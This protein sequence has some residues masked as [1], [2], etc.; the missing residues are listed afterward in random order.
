MDLTQVFELIRQHGDTAYAFIFA[1]AASHSMLIVLLAGYAANMGALD[2]GK[3]VLVCWAGSCFGDV[4]RFWIGRRF[5]TRW[6][7]RFPRLERAVQ[8][9]ARLVDH[10]YLW[11]PMIH[12]YPNGIRSVAG[13]A[14]GMSRLPRST[15]HLLNVV[16]AGIWAVAMVSIGYAFGHIS[17]KTLSDTA[18]GLSLAIMLVFMGLFWILSKRLE[19][20]LERG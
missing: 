4:V 6:L 14:F 10:H 2:W 1:Y 19:R 18:S 3:L 11:I 7:N 16:S 9:A 5:G 8:S 12:R 17:E 15:F 13:F 20:S